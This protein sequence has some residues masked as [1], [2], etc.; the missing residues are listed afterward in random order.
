MNNRFQ[1]LVELESGPYTRWNVV[2]N[3]KSEAL[4]SFTTQTVELSNI[5]SA[6]YTK[7]LDGDVFATRKVTI[8]LAHEVRHW[9]D[10]VGS[11]WGQTLLY[12]GYNALH[13][14]LANDP[15]ELWRIMSFQQALRDARFNSYYT[16]IESHT[17]P[18]GVS[19]WQYQMSAGAR[20]NHQGKISD[21]HPIVFTKFAWLDGTPAC[22]VPISLI[23][24]LE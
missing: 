12:K 11:V 18:D 21:D 20:F 7:A 22:R 23:S 3:L 10:H 15:S 14:R 6:V 8:L 24:L 17:P 2:P 5:D 16:T 1:K 4:Y 13:A 9:I 19:R